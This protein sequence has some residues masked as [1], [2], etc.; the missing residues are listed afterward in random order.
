MIASQMLNWTPLA[1]L[2]LCVIVW[3]TQWITDNQNRWLRI[4]AVCSV[5]IQIICT[6]PRIE[7][8]GAY[9]VSALFAIRLVPRKGHTE[10]SAIR[11]S[12]E[13]TKAK[14]VRWAMVLGSASALVISA[15]LSSGAIGD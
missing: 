5:V 15:L 14:L 6:G 11:E 12:T 2:M 3:P 9:L 13:S 7:M 1:L 8:V 10:P 4:V